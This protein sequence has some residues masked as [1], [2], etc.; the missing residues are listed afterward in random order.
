MQAKIL[1]IQSP[2]RKR[3]EQPA[4]EAL[5]AILDILRCIER[6]IER[7]ERVARPLATWEEE[8]RPY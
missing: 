3:R 7:M 5:A 6:R 2:A 8:G 4:A 1:R